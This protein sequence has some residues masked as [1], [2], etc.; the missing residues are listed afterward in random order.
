MPG[1]IWRH[2][3]V[4][5]VGKLVEQGVW[6]PWLDD[7]NTLSPLLGEAVGSCRNTEQTDT[8]FNEAEIYTGNANTEHPP[9]GV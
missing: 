4:L 6:G 3:G 5:T 2:C 8:H 7:M 1:V 9:G